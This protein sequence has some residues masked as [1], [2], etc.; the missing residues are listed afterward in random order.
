MKQSKKGSKPS[1][2]SKKTLDI[3]HSQFLNEI[4][5]CKDHISDLK[6]QISEIK[7]TICDLESLKARGEATDA[8]INRGIELI[9]QKLDL[10]KRLA[11]LESNF[12]EAQYLTCTADILYKYYELVEKGQCN[13]VFDSESIQNS[14]SN[15][16]S[17]L[18]Y[19]NS[20][21]VS[22]AKTEKQVKPDDSESR[23]ALLDRY[24]MFTDSN[25]IKINGKDNEDDVCSHCKSRNVTVLSNDGYKCC[26]DCHSM[27]YIII[28]HDKPSYKDPPMECTYFAYKRQNH[29][30]EWLAQVQGKETTEIPD[31]V[32][33]KIL[34]E[35]KKQK[36]NNMAELTHEKV[37]EILKR[38]RINKYYEHSVHILNRL[39]GC[40]MPNM[41]PEL[42]E[43]LRSMFK[44]IQTPFLKH[45]PPDRKNFLSYSYVL[46]KMIQLLDKDEYLDNFPL[47]K[48]R[49]KLY[50]QDR[51]WRKICDE[52]GWQFIA[53]L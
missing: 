32:Y 7:D 27:E 53:S 16:N 4:S 20:S 33:D 29:F 44:Q 50:Q 5:K 23:G 28:D 18:Q 17:I 30:N 48:S 34:L 35:I 13:L 42:E 2:T 3:R 21:H 10:E 31:E 8:D 52:L 26:N 19:F 46:H 12:D 39:N 51:T 38:L 47:L 24:L 9:D 11:E 37:R 45:S 40:P 36:I 25:Y 14:S 22:P 41:P 43:R 15:T 1:Q 49:E 6:K